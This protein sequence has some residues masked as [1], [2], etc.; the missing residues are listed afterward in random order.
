MAMRIVNLTGTA[1]KAQQI[2]RNAQMQPGFWNMDDYA[3]EAPEFI[4]CGST[5]DCDDD[6]LAVT[7]MARQAHA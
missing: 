6:F 5:F 3:I 4:P 1:G 2:P 7:L